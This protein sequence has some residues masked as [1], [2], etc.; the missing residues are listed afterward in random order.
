[1]A[2]MILPWLINPSRQISKNKRNLKI[3]Q[4]FCI[5]FLVF[6]QKIVKTARTF[7]FFWLPFVSYLWLNMVKLSCGWFGYATKWRKIK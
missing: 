7:S 1:L 5:G 4:D 3:L 6:S 2:C